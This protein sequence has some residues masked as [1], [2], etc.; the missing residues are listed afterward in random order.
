MKTFLRLCLTAIAFTTF[1]ATASANVSLADVISEGM[2]LQQNQKVPIWGRA[3]PGE[4]VTVRF[5]GQSKSTTALADGEWLIRLDPMKA[6]T[7]AATMT[8]AGRNTIEL[9][10]ILVGEVWLVAGQSNMQRL[11]SETANG[12]AAIAAADHPQIRLFNV[13]RQVAFKHAAPPLA[14]WLACSPQTIK[15]FSAAGYYFGVE[16]E[17]E[18]HVPI[19]L[20]NASYGG[21]QA[22]A[23]TPVEYLLAS[24]D[25]KPTV[26]RTKIWDEERARVRVEY[27]EAIK[28]W[29]ADADKA[30]AAGA[31][32]SP[33]PAVPDALREYRI[34]ASIYDG[35]IAPLIP[36]YIRGA[37]WY[38]GESNEARAQQYGILLPT[39]IKAWRERWGEGDF[40]FGVVQLPN[41]RDP[42][43]DPAD[44]PWSHIR[45]AQRRTVVA[46]PNAG[47]I[48]TIDIGEAH[49]IHPKN[50]L[51]VG[52]RMARWALAD[53]YGRKITKS[54]PMFRD[55]APSHGKI[56]IRF[57]EAG[58][59]LRIRDGSE[60]NEFAIAGEDRKWVWAHAKII[61]RDTIE[62][63]SESVKKPIAVRYAFNN[64][65]RGPNLTND[66]GLP[67]APFRTDNWPG[68]TDGKR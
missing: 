34:A 40:P 25:L 1:A 51:D 37:I 43:P 67:A 4:S 32:P 6:N 28:K 3:D 62:V 49:D 46:T 22:E 10:N 58:R 47:L 13:S 27:D 45:E 26:D 64:N 68:P 11:L 36:F 54:G 21:S 33:S 42:K 2:V 55:A 29:R 48:V 12:D 20:I 31:R 38:Q 56:V 63:W 52:K 66:T 16:L 19:G 17:S 53:V 50:K 15:E 14:R 59:G 60:L 18:L 39:M 24:P 8:V 30:T 57:D 44:E 41:Y 9:R 61:G 35:M 7:T 5:A 65:P 23:W